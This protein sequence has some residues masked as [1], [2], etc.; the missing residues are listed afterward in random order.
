MRIRQYV[1]FALRS[2]ELSAT[3]MATRLGLEPDE[4]LLRGSRQPDPPVPVSHAWKIVCR[5]HG[6]TVDE[7]LAQVLARLTPYTEKIAELAAELTTREG[8]QSG[9]R[10]SVVRYFGSD[11]GEEE[12][13]SGPADPFQKLP[14]Q[15][16]LLGWTLSRETMRFLLATGSSL[17]VDEYG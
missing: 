10:L 3:E 9:A 15:H 17:D 5:R 13:P 12:E 14:G 2:R 1:Y 4:V 7:Q 16:Q 6:L 11:D 8:E